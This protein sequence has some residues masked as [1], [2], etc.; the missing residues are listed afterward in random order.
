MFPSASGLPRAFRCHASLTLPQVRSGGT[1]FAH[2]GTAVHK[3]LEDVPR[4]GR[5]AA[6]AAIE[7]ESARL[8]CEALDVERLPLGDGISYAAEVAYSL[9]LVMGTATEVG[10]GIGRAYPDDGG[11]HGTADLVALS[12]DGATAIVLDAKTG[13]GWMPSAAESEQLK[14]LAL[15]ACRAHG[16][17]KARVAHL[18]LRDD[19]SV[20]TDWAELSAE[21]LARFESEITDLLGVTRVGAPAVEGGWCRYCPAFSACPADRKSTRLNSSH[22]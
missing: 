21:D 7:D 12:S 5:E 4:L 22:Q 2:K 14:M 6:L 16:A 19:G 13:H 20:W 15:M 17:S 10:R 11:L 9:D 1:A 3:F 8:L 18:H